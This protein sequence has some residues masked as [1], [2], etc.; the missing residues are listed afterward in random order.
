MRIFARTNILLWSIPVLVLG[1]AIMINFKMKAFKND[2]S[3]SSKSQVRIGYSS[4]P[5]LESLDPS[6]VPDLSSYQFLASLYSR[7]FLPTDSGHLQLMAAKKIEWIGNSARIEVHQWETIDGY[8][9]GAKDVAFSLKRSILLNSRIHGAI[10]DFLCPEHRLTSPLDE[11][12]GIQVNGDHLILTPQDQDKRAFLLP[13][14]SSADYG[15]IP[16]PSV[17]AS[18]PE[19]PIIDYRNTSG[20]YYFEDKQPTVIQSA[21][22]NHA[23]F[24]PREGRAQEVLF[25]ERR[26]MEELSALFVQKK[27]DVIP[28][29]N[30]LNES[31]VNELA[32]GDGV[33]FFQTEPIEQLRLSFWNWASEQTTSAQR[34]RIVQEIRTLI[35]KQG[36][37]PFGC[38]VAK[39]LFPP[40]TAG[41]LTHEQYLEL[42]KS[43]QK[44][45]LKYIKPNQ[46]PYFLAYNPYL[47]GVD[48]DFELESVIIKLM[49]PENSSKLWEE[50]KNTIGAVIQID[51]SGHEDIS[52][53]AYQF[54]NELWGKSKS[55][56]I[57]WMN[58]YM[59][60]HDQTERL[61]LLKKL[62]YEVLEDVWDYPIFACPYVA[63]AQGGWEL[64]APR[65][66]A[67][68]P[69]WM[70]FQ[71]K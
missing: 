4:L 13:L 32:K 40:T 52:L 11:C 6:K 20:P 35:E 68:T 21:H 59:K 53:V 28:K 25:V 54:A 15:I 9:I 57:A 29:D 67:S 10:Q 38:Q 34:W 61:S 48:R 18:K 45:N 23:H 14:L 50:R 17:D 8:K 63:F 44:L 46:K 24:W 27:I 47:P 70:I 65:L 42:D 58:R 71:K 1:T 64:R 12:P 43:R 30:F 55:E 56:G 36:F 16:I 7:L 33:Q 3:S 62:H 19:F 22:W 37:K 69:W 51:S 31:Q 2:S 60:I 66:Y 41:D 49:T 39:T 26:N 5:Q